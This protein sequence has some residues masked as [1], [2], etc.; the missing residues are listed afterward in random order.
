MQLHHKTQ[1]LAACVLGV[2]LSLVGCSSEGKNQPLDKGTA[3]SS[4]TRFLDAWSKG[5]KPESLE[6]MSP[7]IV[8]RDSDW[9]A[10]KKL[11]RYTLGATSEDGSNLHIKAELVTSAA[12]TP[13]S[14]QTVE[15]IVGTSP[16]IT[17]FRAE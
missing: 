17:I 6:A 2:V 16:V 5:E 4:L 1:A 13:E 8:G 11:V 15:Y 9:D 14:K 12:K 10:G 3:Q 7:R